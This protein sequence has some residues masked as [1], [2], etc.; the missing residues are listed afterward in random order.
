MMQ[1]FAPLIKDILRL[2]DDQVKT[3]IVKRMDEHHSK[4]KDIKVCGT[5][6]TLW[7]QSL[8]RLSL[9]GYLLGRWIRFERV[10]EEVSPRSTP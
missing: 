1:I 2:V 3:V 9:E 10:S 6:L 8:L 4:A 5:C 7:N